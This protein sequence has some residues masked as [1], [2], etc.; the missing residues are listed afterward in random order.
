MAKVL[1][2]ETNLMNIAEAIRGKTGETAKKEDE[3]P[4]DEEN[5]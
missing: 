4:M 2:N 3:K 1:I 5:V